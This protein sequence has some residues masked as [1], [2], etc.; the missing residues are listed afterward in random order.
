MYSQLHQQLEKKIV[1]IDGAMGTMLQNEELT[2]QDFG[3]EA[4]EGC[5][6]NLV[7]TRPDVLKKIHRAYLEAGTDI[8]CTN[9][10]GATPLV[11]NEYGL[12]HL[13][14]EINKR[15]VALAREE[16]DAIST[17]EWP[18]FVAGAIDRKSVV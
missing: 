7:I 12:G 11:L 5:N 1:I 16:V 4:L 8:I 6:E 13:A 9:T 15:A 2:A 18:R 10:F 17:P 3:G 14:E